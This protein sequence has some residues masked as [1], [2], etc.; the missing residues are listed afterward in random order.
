MDRIEQRKIGIIVAILIMLCF[1]AVI[2]PPC[3]SGFTCVSQTAGNGP[4]AHRSK[5]GLWKVI[6]K[7]TAACRRDTISRIGIAEASVLPFLRQHKIHL[8]ET[9][10][11]AADRF[12]SRPVIM[13][14]QGLC[15]YAPVVT[16]SRSDT[17]RKSIKGPIIR[18]VESAKGNSCGNLTTE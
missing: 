2:S 18:I 15:R 7:R 4:V 10:S 8:N 3:F 17:A 13:R 11:R 16:S 12:F 5:K 6:G 9:W 1:N 14:E